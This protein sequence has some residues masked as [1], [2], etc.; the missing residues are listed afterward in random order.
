MVANN[1]ALD[2]G[3]GIYLYRSDFNCKMNSTIKILGNCAVNN[4]GGIYAVSSAIK[5]TYVRDFDRK[6]ALLYVTSNTAING[7][8]IYLAANA[9]LLVL[10]EG[11]VKNSLSNSSNYFIGNHAEQ[12]GG[13]VYVA[14]ETNAAT[15]EGND[16]DSFYSGSATECFFPCR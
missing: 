4:G 12:Y 6:R 5:V 13:A 9:K 15:C 7:G 14:D 11:T 8:G 16:D 3:G 10:K 2:N 1:H